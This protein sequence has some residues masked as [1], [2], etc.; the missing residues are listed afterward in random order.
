MCNSNKKLFFCSCQTSDKPSETAKYIWTLDHYIGS[1]PTNKMGKILGPSAQLGAQ[2]NRA[3]VIEEMNRRHCFDFDYTPQEQDRFYC[4]IGADGEAYA[5]F[6]LLYKNG[7]WQAGNY[8]PFGRTISEQFA[9]GKVKW[10][11]D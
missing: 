4:S 11:E 2:L 9:K 1:K 10:G 6:S 7:Q 3:A 5:Y 8:A